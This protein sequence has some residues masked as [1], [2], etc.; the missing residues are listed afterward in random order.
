M[1]PHLLTVDRVSAG[2]GQVPVLRGVSIHVGAGE[3]VGLFGPNGHGKTTLLRTVSGLLRPSGGTI[4]FDGAG[5]AS[6]R[7]SDIVG[8]GL[9]HAQQG[10]KL[11]GGMGVAETLELAAFTKRARPQKEAMLDRVYGLFP[12]LA[13]RRRQFARTL[14]GGERQMLSIGCAL[15]CVPRLLILDEPTLGLSPRLKEELAFAIDEIRDSGIPLIV[16]EQDVEFLLSLT[17]RLYL[18]EHGEVSRE[19]GKADA[20]DHQEIMNMYFGT[21]EQ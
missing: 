10:N 3:A 6:A 11:F 17:D 1:T 4:R 16:V 18:I 8:A 9:V 14:S 21:T 19:I 2:Y 13:E 20:P 7:P 12:R 15:M 5:I